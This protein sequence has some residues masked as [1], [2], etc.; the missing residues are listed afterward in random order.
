MATDAMMC[1]DCVDSGPT[2]ICCYYFIDMG[3]D[4]LLDLDFFNTSFYFFLLLCRCS[5]GYDVRFRLLRGH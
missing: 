1:L 4:M 2:A 3:A 5:Y